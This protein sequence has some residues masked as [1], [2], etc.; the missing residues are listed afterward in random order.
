MIV[1]AA[2]AALD[3]SR[4]MQEQGVLVVAVRPPTVPSGQA[5]LR[6]CLSAAHTRDQVD[7]VV[8][9]LGDWRQRSG[10]S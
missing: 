10:L 1:G 9:L 2:Q 5:R 3:L 8:K 7:R 4:W 6:L